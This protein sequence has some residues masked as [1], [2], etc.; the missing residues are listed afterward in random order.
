MKPSAISFA[1]QIRRL[2]ADERGAISVIMGV[3]LIPLVGALAIGFEV[4]N[5][6][7][8]TRDMQNA[9]D[10]AAM[11][12]ATNAKSNYDIEA[13]AVAARYGFVDGANTV[14]VAASNTATCPDGTNT[15]YSVTI[16]GFVPLLFSQVVGFQGDAIVNGTR[17]KRLSSI[18]VAKPSKPEELCMVALAGSGAAQGIRTN[19]ASAGNMNGC[20]VM[21]NTNA[22]C[23]G[24]NLGAGFGLA[25][26]TS[27]GCGVTPMSN[28]P[29]VAD[30]YLSR[31]SNIPP[32]SASPCGG[33]FPQESK[34]GNSYSVAVSNQL[35]G[36]LSLSAGN[37]FKCGDQ[38]LTA[39]T[40]ITTPVGGTNP[41]VLIIEN[42]QLD[43][44]GHTLRTS[45]GSAVTLVFSGTNGSGSV[46]PYV[47]APTDNTNG[48]G[49]VLDIAAP[50]SGPWSGVAIYQDPTLTSGVD[51]SA[52][53]NSPTWNITGLVYMPHAS[54]QLKG[55][56][57]KASAGKSCLVLIA[58]NFQLSGNA[59]IAKTDVGHC[60]D[61]GLTMP[62]ATILRSA[63]VL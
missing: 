10:A 21:S 15:C 34:H 28:I 22:Q 62:S 24:S 18:A 6:Y 25:H 5:W 17:E 45:G 32:L 60:G 42:G 14:T 54:V 48:S 61:A 55:A 33:N 37:N 58:D 2:F 4:S 50:S 38:M 9:A 57:D 36:N 27:D 53:G 13:K 63:L 40:V 11:A 56:I 30:P 51:V 3:L 59:G 52:A 31:A 26:G 23:N 47:H 44:N 7:M 35:S 46:G 29:V 49:G 20:N 12:A 43:L 1:K 8:T 19:G 41:A 39:D 16:A